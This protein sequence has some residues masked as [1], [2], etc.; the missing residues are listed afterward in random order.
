[1]PVFEYKGLTPQGKNVKGTIDSE[2]LRTARARL[3]KDGVFVIDLKNKKETKKRKAGSQANAVVSVQDLANMT[4]LLATL[5]KANVPMVDALQAVSEQLENPLLAEVIADI[6]NNVNE[7]GQLFKS[8]AKY[9]KI[10]DTIYVSM[11]EAGELSGSLDAILGRLADFTENQNQLE[12]KVKSALYYPLFMF[13]FT[14]L[15]LV[16][17]F[18]YVI[19]KMVTV[20]ES[21]PELT[22]PW[23]TVAVIGFSDILINYWIVIAV[24][25]VLAVVI[26]KNWKSTASGKRQYDQMVLNLP[27]VGKTARVVAISR[28]TRTL[29]TLLQGGVPMLTAMG[30][31]K[32][33]VNNEILAEAIGQAR[34]NISEGESVAGPLKKSGQFPPIV[35]HM[36]NI[37]EKTGELE[38]M[39][40]QVSE[41][42]D[43]QVK[44]SIDGLTSLLSPLTIILMGGVIGII[45]FSIM[46]PMFQMSNL[47]G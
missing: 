21:A 7:G 32:N 17:I 39:L 43:F 19:P 47:G 41:S 6:K 45:V 36:I 4:R 29:S 1:M 33:V 27:I 34:D 31:V 11:V 10:F 26:F 20:F 3:K 23:Y 42:Y 24:G 22:L 2:N 35:I 18:V 37:G 13:F 46:V 9:P 30:I 5:L 14:G 25:I 44:T 8:L 16:V 38:H 12:S 40:T 28:F 15:L